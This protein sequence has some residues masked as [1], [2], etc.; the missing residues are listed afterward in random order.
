[1][2]RLGLHKNLTLN[3]GIVAANSFTVIEKVML[4]RSNTGKTSTVTATALA[5]IYASETLFAAGNK[6]LQ[7]FAFTFTYT[8]P[9]PCNGLQPCGEEGAGDCPGGC[10]CE[11]GLCVGATGSQ[12]CTDAW[13]EALMHCK[14]LTA[15]TLVSGESAAYDYTSG[16]VYLI[17]I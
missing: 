8:E 9:C 3:T 7:E 6:S 14:T 2:A 1:M 16:T 5:A 4:D 11:G 13:D 12:T 10:D 17:S 15:Q